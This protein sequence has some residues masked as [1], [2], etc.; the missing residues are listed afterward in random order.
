MFQ[1]VPIELKEASR[2]IVRSDATW[3]EAVN[4]TVGFGHGISV[5]PL[6]VVAG[7]AAVANG[8]LLM[9]PTILATDPASPPEGTRVMKAATS[10]VMRRLMR[11]VVT[12]GFGKKAEV[13]GYYPGGKTGTA[14]KNS[15]KGYKK[16]ANVS[17]F[18][19]VFPMH[20]PRF[21]VYIMLDEPHGTAATGGYSTAGQVAAPAAG[22]V[23]TRIGPIMGLMPD[24]QNMAAIDQ[25]LAIPMQPARGMVLGP[26]RVPEQKPESAAPPKIVPARIPPGPPQPDLM[27]KT[28]AVPPNSPPNRATGAPL[29]AVSSAST[30]AP[31]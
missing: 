6:H 15:G 18:M 21:A 2:P 30:V 24:I 8:G 11:L 29:V 16:H 7:T 23:I 13:P 14:E 20:A 5:T 1:R 26:I 19:S 27:R 9:R 17:A 31:R 4:Y 3:G 10:D 12:S 28:Q 22:K 25:A